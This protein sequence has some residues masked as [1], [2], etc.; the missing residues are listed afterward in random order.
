[1][2]EPVKIAFSEEELRDKAIDY[3]NDIYGQAKGSD[4]QDRWF[5]RSGLMLGFIID[6]FNPPDP[7]K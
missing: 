5:E 7:E 3:L 2:S 6:L 4:D 1:M